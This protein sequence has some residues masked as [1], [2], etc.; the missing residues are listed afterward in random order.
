[1]SSEQD[2]RGTRRM[3]AINPTG[4]VGGAELV[5]ERLLEAAQNHGNWRLVAAIPDGRL[6]ERL[7]ARH[8]TVVAIPDLKLP[9]G[10]RLLAVPRALIRAAGAARRIRRAAVE[11]GV[12]V[13]VANGLLALPAV[14]LARPRCPVVLLVHD[15]LDRRAFRLVLRCFGRIVDTA[16][17]PSEAVARP[18]RKLGVATRVIPNGTPWPVPLA[19]SESPVPPVVGELAAL[20]PPKAQDVLLDAVARLTRRDVIVEL[21]GSALPKDSRYLT[22]LRAQARDSGLGTRVR[23]LGQV[24]DPLARLRRWSV[25]VLPSI[26]PESFGLVLLEA[27]SV[28]VPAVATDH[29]GPPEI[30]GDAGLLVPP[31][32]PEA[33]AAAIGRLLDDA[34]LRA[35]CRAAGPRRVAAVYTLAAQQDALLSALCEVTTRNAVSLARRDGRRSGPNRAPGRGRRAARP[36]G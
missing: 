5:L 35:R 13:I 9:M 36:M 33:L 18:L 24:G 4:L 32:D 34:D 21:A 30:I 12:D 23:F 29:G 31:R 27:M 1:M 2:Q 26:V 11:L 14:R 28:G 19:P 10:P 25:A 16:V 6:T 22:R 3:L 15:M 7:Q 17:V 8:V 20:T